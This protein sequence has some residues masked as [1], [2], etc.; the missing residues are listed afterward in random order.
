V[1]DQP[2][3]A[4]VLSSLQPGQSVKVLARRSDGSQVLVTVILGELPS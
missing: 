3:L 4:S 2:A 1:P